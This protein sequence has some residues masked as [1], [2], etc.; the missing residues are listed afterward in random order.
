M[1]STFQGRSS[2]RWWTTTILDTIDISCHIG[3]YKYIP[4]PSLRKGPWGSAVQN[5]LSFFPSHWG[6]APFPRSRAS[7]QPLTQHPHF[8]PLIHS[9]LTAR[10]PA[11]P[12][13]D[14]LFQCHHGGQSAKPQRGASSLCSPSCS[15]LGQLWTRSILSLSL[16]HATDEDLLP[17]SPF[18]CSWRALLHF[19]L[20]FVLLS[21]GDKIPPLLP[22]HFSFQS[23]ICLSFSSCPR[24]FLLFR[25]F[26]FLLFVFSFSS[27]CSPH[28]YFP[29]IVKL[30][31]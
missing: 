6:S 23:L 8:P 19:G 13:T 21:K 27:Y 7:G 25:L 31:L 30:T 12:E 2:H 24:R 5:W 14:L 20:H 4:F 10:L 9:W 3:L 29:V 11:S 16:S 1:L 15:L 28:N 26:F 17:R 22:P 18:Q